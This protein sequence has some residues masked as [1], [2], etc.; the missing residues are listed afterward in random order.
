MPT[1]YEKRY[2]SR[3]AADPE[4]HEAH[5]R[6]R[7]GMSGADLE[8]TLRVVNHLDRGGSLEP[9]HVA[10][11]AKMYPANADGIRSMAAQLNASGPLKGQYL[12]G[13]LTRDD[14]A[15]RGDFGAVNDDYRAARKLADVYAVEDMAEGINRK[16]EATAAADRTAPK[17]DP[18]AQR[19]A[20]D[21][22]STR[23]IIERAMQPKGAAEFKQAVEQDPDS[24]QHW[25]ARHS[26]ADRLE[27]SDAVLHPD[28]DVSTREALAS[29][30]DK[31]AI[32]TWGRDL[33]V[34]PAE[35]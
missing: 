14:A 13:V 24:P 12:L 10:R 32:G 26:A 8:F 5:L 27:A 2:A 1:A 18:A 20:E 7:Y 28:S 29:A 4:G 22:L 35:D 17:S 34:I 19:P 30:W 16:R 11:F 33:G 25:Q 31:D 3:A 15:V 9:A 21:P 23:A 6:Q